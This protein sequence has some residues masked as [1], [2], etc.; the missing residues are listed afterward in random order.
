MPDNDYFFAPSPLKIQADRE[1]L[2]ECAKV[3]LK[4][5]WIVPTVIEDD[6]IVTFKMTIEDYRKLEQAVL[7]AT[8]GWA[9]SQKDEGLNAGT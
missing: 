3:I 4:A 8:M 9:T 1:R 2:L 7:W 6:R 5:A